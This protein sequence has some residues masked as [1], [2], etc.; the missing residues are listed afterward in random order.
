MKQKKCCFIIN[1][2]SSD[3]TAEVNVPATW[4]VSH[5]SF[6]PGSEEKEGS[7]WDPPGTCRDGKPHHLCT[8]KMLQSSLL[9]QR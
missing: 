3:N 8:G 2:P 1:C 6:P 5:L 7:G 9:N 4:H